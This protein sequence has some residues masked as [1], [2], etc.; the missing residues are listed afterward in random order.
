[1]LLLAGQPG[2]PAKLD[3][4]WCCSEFNSSDQCFAINEIFLAIRPETWGNAH[5]IRL[6]KNKFFTRSHITSWK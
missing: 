3:S 1:M 4:T 6:T 5:P 2:Q